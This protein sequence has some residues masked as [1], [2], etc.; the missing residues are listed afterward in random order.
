MQAAVVQDKDRELIMKEVDKPTASDTDLI[1][2]VSHCGVC[3][4]DIHAANEG[5]V[6][7]GTVLGHE[8]SGTIEETGPNVD[9]SDW[10]VGSRVTALPFIPCGVCNKCQSEDVDYCHKPTPLG[11]LRRLPGAY[12]EYVRISSKLAINIPHNVSMQDAAVVEPMAVSLVAWQKSNPQQ[13]A[14]VL[15]IGAGPIGLALAKWAKY[16]GA[17]FIAISEMVPS[18][19]ERAQTTGADLVIDAAQE[20]DP[21]EAMQRLSGKAPQIIFECVGRPMLQKLMKIAP[22][23]SHLCLLGACMENEEINISMISTKNLSLSI[24]FGYGLKEFAYI[25]DLLDRGEI[26]TFPL[27][28]AVVPLMQTPET[29]ELLR[30][31]NDHC[32]VLLSTDDM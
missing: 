28:S 2:K 5:L 20:S 9:N 24:P 23:G 7:A 18:R 4:S 26:D 16:F 14:D 19:I 6:R 11:F 31:P 30:K 22:H 21:V 3:G 10:Q 17:D 12:A 32:K 8:F 25:L 1:I 13:G 29:F 27:I 15:I